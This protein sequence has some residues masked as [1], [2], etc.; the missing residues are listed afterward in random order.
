M[1]IKLLQCVRLDIVPA[2]LFWDYSAWRR[3]WQ[4]RRGLTQLEIMCRSGP[5]CRASKRKYVEIRMKW[6]I[7][8]P[9]NLKARKGGTT[10][11]LLNKAG[12]LLALCSTHSLLPCHL[13]PDSLHVDGMSSPNLSSQ[14][15]LSLLPPQTSISAQSTLGGVIF[16]KS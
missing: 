12:I 1:G 8:F 14:D 7:E 13:L 6:R 10:E 16:A 9:L 5:Q 2:W 4:G 11:E 15:S 3:T